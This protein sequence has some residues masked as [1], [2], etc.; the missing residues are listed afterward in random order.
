MCTYHLIKRSDYG[1]NQ[2]DGDAKSAKTQVIQRI[3]KYAKQYR[4][5]ICVFYLNK[6]H[7]FSISSNSNSNF[8]QL[9]TT[10][11]FTRVEYV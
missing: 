1:A 6:I 7:D 2:A 10:E 11:S 3:T 5:L 9:L 8:I 4:N